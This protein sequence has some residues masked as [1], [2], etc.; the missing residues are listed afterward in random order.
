MI[1][2]E[3]DNIAVK[4]LNTTIISKTLKKELTRKLIHMLIALTPFAASIDF[5]AT[6]ALLGAGIIVYSFAETLRYTGQSIG[7]ISQITSFAARDRDQGKFVL[8]P[9]TLAAGAMISLLL[10]TPEIATIAIFA[11]AFGDGLSSLAGKAF[12]R[13]KIPFT[14]GKTITGSLVCFLAIYISS[15]QI[16]RNPLHSLILAISG[17]LIEL[18]PSKDLDNILLPCASG[19][20]ATFILQ[21]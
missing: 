15:F 13:I 3:M 5:S 2:A 9:I 20:V 10:F 8:G 16:L 14:G 11:L 12:G 1:K 7:I 18:L 19:L 4:T 21:L 6:I 17:A